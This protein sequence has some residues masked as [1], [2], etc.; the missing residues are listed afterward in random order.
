MNIFVKLHG[1]TYTF[2]C[3]EN[4]NL[5]KYLILAFQKYI[6]YLGKDINNLILIGYNNF[7]QISNFSIAGKTIK[8]GQGL[9]LKQC[10]NL[11]TVNQHYLCGKIK[12]FNLDDIK[13][14]KTLMYDSH[15][16]IY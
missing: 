9:K 15:Y 12:K 13:Y 4:T 7:L 14:I 1:K 3:Q 2:I 6:K 11:M 16:L 8:F 10:H 5:D